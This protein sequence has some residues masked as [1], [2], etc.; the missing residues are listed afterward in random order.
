MSE[1]VL[2]YPVQGAGDPPVRA[3][4]IVGKYRVEGQ[5]GSGGMGLVMAATHTTL[6]QPVALKFMHARIADRGVIVERF[7]REARVVA[8]LKNEHVARVYDVGELAS[9]AP[10]IVMERL[11]GTDLSTLL[12][13]RGPLAVAVAAEIVA[14]A[15]D[16]IAEAHAL[17]I[18]HRDLKPRNLFLTRKVDGS[19]FVKILDFGI[20]K[21]VTRSETGE[22]DSA[23][24]GASEVIGSPFNMPPEQ[25]LGSRSIDARADVWS[26]GAVL[27]QLLTAKQP[28]AGR[29]RAELYTQVLGG[30]PRPLRVLRP[31][32]GDEL[33]RIVARCLEKEAASRYASVLE[34]SRDLRAA[35]RATAQPSGAS[36]V[37]GSTPPVAVEARALLS[38]RRVHPLAIGVAAAFAIGVG[39]AATAHR[40][41]ASPP[42][43]AADALL[44]SAPATLTASS[45]R[46]PPTID[47]PR[48]PVAP[49]TGSL[50]AVADAGAGRVIV[51]RAPRVPFDPRPATAVPPKPT[52]GSPGDDD[53]V[54]RERY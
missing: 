18:V 50:P 27:F 6:G 2:A 29:T 45:P 24:T 30:G 44:A 40:R 11:E 37:P 28:F 20:S 15:C 31:E 39:A 33:A 42:G 53:D 16:G 12:K 26:L 14:Q 51:P 13:E 21:W 36:D 17:G 25:M 38:R 23:L 1:D 52:P 22:E 54:F 47:E 34:L 9:G 32:A 43:R 8:C 5:L 49:V 46:P 35:V 3:G 19:P 48:A 7:L 10:F 4:D 41:P